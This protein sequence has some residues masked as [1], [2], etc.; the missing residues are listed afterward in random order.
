MSTPKFAYVH[1]LVA[2]LS[3]PTESEGFEQIIDFF[4]AN[5]IKYDLTAQIHAKVDG[6]KVIISEAIIKR[7]LKFEDK[8]GVDCLSNEVIFEQ[9]PLIGEDRLILNE[10]MEICTKLQQRVI[11]LENTKI[12]QAQEISSLKKRVK[13]L[14]KKRRSITHGL[15]RLYK[16]G[17][18]ARVES[19]AKEQSLD[20]EDASKQERNIANI[21]ADVETTLVNETAED[22]ERYDDPEMFDTD[23]LNDEEV[24]VE[25]VNA[26]T[27]T[28]VSI[29]DITLDQALVEIKTSK[30]KARDYELATRLQEEK[31]GELTIEDKS[32]LFVE[33]M[34]K[35]KKHF[36]KLR[37]EEQI[38]KSPTKAQKRNQILKRAGDKLDQGRSKKQK[39]KD[40]NEQDKLKR[41]LEIIPDDGDDVTIDATPLSIKT[42]I[43]DYKIYK[44]G[45][46]SYF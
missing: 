1:N 20:E 24:V 15:K 43:I 9:L 18:S 16:I 26:S 27:T 10:L 5:P 41:C 35:R 30:P 39:V 34:D 2:F 14:E 12:V 6:K 19:F 36:A 21:D 22:Q 31:Q 45:K 7:D 11:D 4:N 8:G 33:L 38:R 23:V 25:D 17:L 42:L 46:K 44:E 28:V 37:A 3:K 40:D 29:D 32:R 13:R